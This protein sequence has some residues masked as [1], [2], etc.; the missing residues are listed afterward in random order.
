MVYKVLYNPK[1]KR[2]ELY[3]IS[4]ITKLRN[5]LSKSAAAED[6]PNDPGLAEDE[7]GEDANGEGEEFIKKSV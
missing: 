4:E 3:K 1:T 6:N 7:E 2:F 5:K